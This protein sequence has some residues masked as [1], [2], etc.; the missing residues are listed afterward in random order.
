VVDYGK[1]YLVRIVNAAMNAELFFAIANH[2]LTVVGMDGNYLKPILSDYLVMRPRQTM[3]VL[4]TA[5]QSLS[6]YY[7]AIR[8]YDSAKPDIT[9]YDKTNATA[10]LM[11]NGNYTAP[12]YPTYPSGTLPSYEDFRS[13]D[14]F[15]D[16]L[17]SL[18]TTDHPVNAPLNVTT[19][20]YITV[21]MNQII[22]PNGSCDGINGNRLSSSLNNI[23]FVN[24][25]TDVLQAYYR[26]IYIYILTLHSSLFNFLF[27]LIMYSLLQNMAG[28]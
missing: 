3:D 7:V 20:M 16:R 12:N 2:S 9:D 1:T 11:Y 6:H 25:T 4:L 5:N 19:K 26:C 13:A 10:I 15:L 17:R 27:L 14:R 8:Q 24:P 18:A 22:C 23:S 28:T 21:S